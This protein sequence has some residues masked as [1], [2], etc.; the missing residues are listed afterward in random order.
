MKKLVLLLLGLCTMAVAQKKKNVSQPAA[1]AVPDFHISMSA[2]KWQFKEGKVTFVEKNGAM[3]MR[4]VQG[5]Q[6]AVVLKDVVFTNGTI[7]FDF[8]PEAPMSLGSS[9]TVYFHG[10]AQSNDVEIL[11]IRARPKT[12]TAN[13]GVQ[14]CPILKG[15]NMWD[16]YP[17][18]Q[19]PAM[20]EAGKANHL[21]M[22]VSGKQMKVY[23]NDMNRPTLYIPKLEG[24]ATTG[25]LAL[26]GGMTVWNM[27]VKPDITGNL[28]PMEGHDL[29]DHDAQYIRNWAMTAPGNLPDRQEVTMADIPK[30][31]AFTASVSAERQG[32]INLTRKLGGNTA[33]RVVWLKAII[34]TTEAQKNM[35]Q[36]GFSDEVWVFLNGSLAYVD[37]NLYLQ[38]SMRKYPA[39]RISVQNARADLNL[40]A[41]ANE[42][43]IA[44]ANDFYGWGIIAR[45]ENMEGVEF[46]K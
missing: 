29:T 18:Y 40:K 10:D 42:L 4:I 20:F 23:V 7:E 30:P 44:V 26:D 45:L 6:G 36:L 25:M 21:K 8:E 28:P 32:L 38:P 9:P 33:R 27:Q 15:V 12:P 5:N 24:N 31:E 19:A 3:A 11:Y 17:D 46:V 16:M 39:G 2:D 43:L 41:G 22:V 13:D 1:P 14:Y 37:K 35:L 34:K